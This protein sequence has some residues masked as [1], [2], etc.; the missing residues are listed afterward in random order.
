M[1][2]LTLTKEKSLFLFHV[3]NNEIPAYLEKHPEAQINTKF[4]F[5]VNM[6]KNVLTPIFTSIHDASKSRIPEFEQFE[7]ERKGI[8][9]SSCERNKAGLPVRTKNGYIIKNEKREYVDAALLSLNERYKD[10]LEKRK[11]EEKELEEMLKEEISI[12]ICQTSFVNFPSWLTPWQIEQL[13]PLALEQTDEEIGN[14]IA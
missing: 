11:L 12:S 8:L 4:S 1:A 2:N 3:L 9:E 13:R 5:A 7:N 14:L 6:A 10:T